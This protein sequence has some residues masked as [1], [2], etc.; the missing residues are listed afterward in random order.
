M[1]KFRL[2]PAAIDLRKPLTTLGL[3]EAFVQ[4][5]EPPECLEPRPTLPGAD[6][7]AVDGTRCL[8]L[9]KAV[10]KA[11]VEVN[12]QGTEA[13]AATA[14]MFEMTASVKPQPIHLV[15]NR[16]FI[17]LIRNTKTKT[18]LFMGRVLEP[19]PGK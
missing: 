1:P 6:F 8:F 17:F 12:E 16:P 13:A 19:P 18:L 14:L 3:K 7:S 5:S 15:V 10:H 9:S 4:P 2:E 11:F